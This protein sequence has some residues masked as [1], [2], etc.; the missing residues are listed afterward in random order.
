MGKSIKRLR[1]NSQK[2]LKPKLISPCEN[3]TSWVVIPQ[4]DPINK[5]IRLNDWSAVRFLDD[6]ISTEG[7][8]GE[9]GSDNLFAVV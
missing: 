7:G 6:G 9:N 2:E 4:Y 1:L 8:N 3:K 5:R